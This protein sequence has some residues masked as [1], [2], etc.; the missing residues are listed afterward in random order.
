MAYSPLF[1][2]SI[3][4]S[5]SSAM[6][7]IWQDVKIN[8]RKEK[9]QNHKDAAILNWVASEIN[10]GDGGVGDEGQSTGEKGSREQ[11]SITQCLRIQSSPNNMENEGRTS[12]PRQKG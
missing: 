8:L 1:K 5:T 10:D 4:T 11:R 2:K 6:F 7:L 9:C 3:S 12:V